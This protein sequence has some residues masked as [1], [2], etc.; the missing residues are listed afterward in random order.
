MQR[1]L[2]WE[3]VNELHAFRLLDCDPNVIRFKEQPCEIEYLGG[4]G[5]HRHFPDIMVETR[6]R[7]ELW[8]VKPVAQ[9]M[10]P[11]VALRTQLLVRELPRFGYTYRLV[12]AHELAEQPRLNNAGIL[13][14]FGRNKVPELQREYVRRI[15]VREGS[16]K[17]GDACSGRLGTAGREVV[18]RMLLEGALAF[19]MTAPIVPT[20]VFRLRRGAL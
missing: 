18:C 16:L 17:W 7:K 20:T 8:E 1:C 19:D 12:L 4:D 2:Q 9:A 11:E 13:L 5:L 6:V 3:S 14:R 10:Q 15:I